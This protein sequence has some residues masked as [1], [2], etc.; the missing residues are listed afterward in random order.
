VIVVFGTICL[1]RVRRV[2]ALPPSG[3]YVEVDSEELFLG[4]EAAN[5]ANALAGWGADVWLGGN[6]LGKEP[7]AD[8]IKAKL[9]QLTPHSIGIAPYTAH[10]P[11]CDIYVTPDG[12]RTMIGLGF[13]DMEPIPDVSLIPMTAGGWLTAEPNMATVSRQVIRAA[14]EAGM[15]TYLMDF[16]REDEPIGPQ[17][18]WQSST[19]WAGKRGNVQANLKWVRDWVAKYGCFAILSDGANG[20][21]AGGADLPTRYYPAFPS[22]EVVDTTGAGDAFRAGM[23]LGLDAKRPIA[24][25]LRFASAAG[26]LNCRSL[27]ASANVPTVAEIRDFIALHPEIS[28][29]YG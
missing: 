10:T 15:R 19:D 20:L 28:A 16:I 7:E 29:A 17:S 23:L 27:G 24:D 5:T 8:L 14:N 6:D 18:V 9:G 1:D 22:P 4:G 12:D 11:V 25:C 21:V 2:P 13:R 26:A 3:G